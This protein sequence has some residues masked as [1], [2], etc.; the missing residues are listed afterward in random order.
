NTETVTP[1]AV[2]APTAAG[3]GA[4][5]INPYSCSF[6]ATLSNAH[7]AGVSIISG[8]AGVAEAANDNG[9][10]YGVFN[11]VIFLNGACTG[12]ANATAGT[13]GLTGIDTANGT[14][15]CNSTAVTVAAA[16]GIV[17]PRAGLLKNLQ[18]TAT[19]AGTNASSGAVTF[20][21]N[22]SATTIT[23]TVGTGTSCSDTT[24]T[25]SVA[26][27]DIISVTYTDQT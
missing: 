14:I 20:N 11:G 5:T 16:T 9:S 2:S 22:G 19:A 3:P 21:K 17:M 25:V 24:H 13:Y 4:S 15:A 6:T 7:N 23:C 1:S 10:A 18:V 12:T 26:A 27:G 8:D